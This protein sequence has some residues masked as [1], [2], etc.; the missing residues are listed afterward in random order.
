MLRVDHAGEYGAVRIYEGQMAVLGNDP[1]TR[2][3]LEEMKAHEE[4]HLEKM[5]ELLPRYRVRPTILLPVWHVAGLALGA[6]TALMGKRAAMAC[7]AAVE[8]V[9]TDHYN[10]QIRELHSDPKYADQQELRA[11][12]K[13]CRDEE[14]EHRQIALDNGA[15]SAP[16]YTALSN[17][18][19]TGCR[20]AIR[21]ATW[22]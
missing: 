2:A 14:E 5:Q 1:E 12:L 6:G 13:K 11:L 21:V 9:I 10:D 22:I 7:T 19:K 3:Q 8:E 18:I 17:A 20:V 4:E 16:F 15:E